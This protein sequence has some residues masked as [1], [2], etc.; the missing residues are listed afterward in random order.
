MWMRQCERSFRSQ[1][2]LRSKQRR[3]SFPP[4]LR[5]DMSQGYPS[6][7]MLPERASDDLEDPIVAE[8]HRVRRE[9]FARHDSD[10]GKYVRYLRAMDDEER[11]RGRE[12]ITVPLRKSSPSTS[13]AP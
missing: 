3:L 8:V 6:D 4:G 13:D 7:Q 2:L 9:I 10:L 5:A 1:T 12:I 11:K